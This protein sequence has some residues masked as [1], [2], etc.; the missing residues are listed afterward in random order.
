MK[1]CI[2]YDLKTEITDVIGLIDIIC[3]V[4]VVITLIVKAAHFMIYV[5]VDNF[6][7][8]ITQVVVNMLNLF[9]PMFLTNVMPVIEWTFQKVSIAALVV[10]YRYNATLNQEHQ[11]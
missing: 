2:I 5:Q 10:C 4:V 8:R 11:R 1:L 9:V 7:I 3:I 6:N